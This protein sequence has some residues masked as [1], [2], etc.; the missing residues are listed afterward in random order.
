VPRPLYT[1]LEAMLRPDEISRLLGEDVTEVHLADFTPTSAFSGSVFLSIALNGD[2]RPRLFVK[3]I[4]T[5]DWMARVTHD[6]LCRSVTVW[7]HGLLDRFPPEISGGVIAC[8]K[9]EQGHAILMA[10]VRDDLMSDGVLMTA[11]D[12]DVVL[13]ALAALHTAFWLDPSLLDPDLGLCRP[14][15]VLM[16]LPPKR[17]ARILQEPQ[18]L[19]DARVLELSREGWE[20]LPDFIG[21]DAADRVQAMANANSA[22]SDALSRYPWTLVHGDVRVANLAVRRPAVGGDGVHQ[23]VA[24]DMA[25]AARMPPALDLG[26]YVSTSSS[27][28]C[29]DRADVIEGYRARLEDRL[30]ARFDTA[31]WEPQL[32]LALMA[33]ALLFLPFFAGILHKYESALEHPDRQSRF[34]TLQWMSEYVEIGAARL[35]SLA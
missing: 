1:S 23:V 31:W 16:L 32:D 24:L 30:G 22:L 18:T 28:L 17:V 6:D 35:R 3:R 29:C 15:K 2:P 11:R 20:V 25:R 4:G 7:Q 19:A 26:W 9:D 21:A 8:S 10:N 27:V 12:N 13:D 34:D 5:R 33:N 14:D